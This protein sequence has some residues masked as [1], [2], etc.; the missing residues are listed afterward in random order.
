MEGTGK[1]FYN[2]G[3]IYEGDFKN[4]KKEGNGKIYYENGD[5]YEGEFKN[6]VRDGKGKL[7]LD[8]G[9]IIDKIYIN[10]VLV[11]NDKK[12]DLIDSTNGGLIEASN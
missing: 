4:G 2:N 8:N 3:D 10:D 1:F 12:N 7:F 11:D 6:D 5:R 9:E